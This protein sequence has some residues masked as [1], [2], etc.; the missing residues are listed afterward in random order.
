[1]PQL[2]LL[3][4]LFRLL[5]IPQMTLFLGQLC[6]F[7]IGAGR[8]IARKEELRY[9]RRRKNLRWVIDILVFLFWPP[10]RTTFP[11]LPRS[12][13]CRSSCGRASRTALLERA[14]RGY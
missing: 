8:G 11:L 7:A 4:D 9:G 1:M 5:R 10:S 13:R 14:V 3:P 6:I 2:E 12:R